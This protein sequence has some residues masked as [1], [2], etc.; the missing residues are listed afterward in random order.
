MFL[1]SLFSKVFKAL[2]HPWQVGVNLK[3]VKV[4]KQLSKKCIGFTA[5]LNRDVLC[6]DEVLVSLDSYPVDLAGGRRHN[7]CD[8]QCWGLFYWQIWIPSLSFQ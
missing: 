6:L 7:K 3:N 4:L 5:E 8:E 2:Y 1:S